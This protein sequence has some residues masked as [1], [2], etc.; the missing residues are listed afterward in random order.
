VDKSTVFGMISAFSLVIGSIL[1]QGELGLFLS[2][3]SFFIVTGGVISVTVVN[4]R[5]KDLVGAFNSLSENLKSS[6]VDLR[7]DIELMNMFARKAR[8]NGM[9]ALED[10]IHNISDPFLKNGFLYIL[11]GFKKETLIS[12]LNDQ[13]A[14]AERTREKSV[15]IL[16]SMASYSPAFGMI[17][18]VIGLILMLQNI[19]DPESLGVGLAIALLTT[20]Y[21]TILANMIFIP[22]SGKLDHLSEKQLTRKK[23]YIAAIISI[24]EEENPRIMENKM[25]NYLLPEERAEYL[26][27]YDKEKF[28]K[29]REEKLYE[30]WKIYQ[31]EPWQNLIADL[32]TG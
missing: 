1:F 17:G 24:I 25:L 23:M 8:R 10:D 27:Y 13:L 30:K 28:D 18:T 2:L 15:G 16:S 4:F 11:D 9:L 5:F 20:L 7:T 6:D 3:S 29:Q 32:A 31:D 19:E 22:L 21:G 26:A 12:I 14:S